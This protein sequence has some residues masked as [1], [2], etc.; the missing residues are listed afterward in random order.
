MSLYDRAYYYALKDIARNVV[1][2]SINDR[3]RREGGHHNWNRLTFGSIDKAAV[4]YARLEW[5]KYY[6]DATHHGFPHS[7][8]F[9][10]RK[11]SHRP[12]FFD[13]AIWQ[14]IGDER[15]LQ[16]MALGK[17]SRGK[18]HLTVNWVE[19]SFAPTY[20]RGG[21]LAPI[22]AC[23]EEYAKLLG[24]ERVLVKEAVD[25][26]KYGRYGY[27]PYELPKVRRSYLCRE[28]GT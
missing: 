22:L 12:S 19:R 20:L 21:I 16:G 2:Q 25:P 14:Q 28:L 13:L 18:T 24:C 17:P 9:L 3:I 5:P 23:A 11:F 15:V 27:T 7:W 26:A 8:E 10:Y 1:A 4:D 6:S